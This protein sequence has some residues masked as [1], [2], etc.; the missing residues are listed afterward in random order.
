VRQIVASIHDVGPGTLPEVRWLLG[1]LD[2]AGIRPRVLKVIP[3]EAGRGDL[4]RHPAVVDLL[5]QE[6]AAGSEIVL[7]G[8]THRALQMRWRGSPFDRWRAGLFAGPAAELLGCPPDELRRR[9]VA[10]REIAEAVGL[11]I[12][13]FCPPAWLAPPELAA[14]LT[15]AGFHYLVTFAWLHDLTSGR[16]R[17]IPA[18]GYMGAGPLQEALLGLE[19][20][21]LQPILPAFPVL[22]VFLHPQGAPRSA[23]A[24]RVLDRL[25]AWRRAAEPTTYL[26]LLAAGG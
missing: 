19:G 24:H 6:A 25:A 4:R 18:W 10:A 21:A 26:Q 2:E 13:G 9:V 11:P 3:D 12:A 5:R 20:L 16:R 15:E 1:R 23:A 7:H 8:L 17:W 22:R 14:V